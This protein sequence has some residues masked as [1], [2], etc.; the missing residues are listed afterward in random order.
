MALQ[1]LPGKQKRA[2]VTQ[3]KITQTAHG[4]QRGDLVYYSTVTAQ[5]ELAIAT[6]TQTIAHGIVGDFLADTFWLVTNGLFEW[7]GHG[8]N[9]STQYYLS[10]TNAGRA[11]NVEPASVVQKIFIPVDSDHLLLVGWVFQE[12][13]TSSKYCLAAPQG[14]GAPLTEGDL[15]VYTRKNGFAEFD[16][17]DSKEQVPVMRVTNVD[18]SVT[19][20]LIT[21][22]EKGYFDY[23]SSTG[24]DTL[25]LGKTVYA[26]P[27]THRI[28]DDSIGNDYSKPGDPTIP[29]I[30][31]GKIVQNLGGGSY[32]IV[33][34]P[35]FFGVD[36][37]VQEDTLERLDLAGVNFIED[38]ATFPN[39]EATPMAVEDVVSYAENNFYFYNR[40]TDRPLMIV[41]QLGTSNDPDLVVACHRGELI[42]YDL[43]Q[44]GITEGTVLYATVGSKVLSVNGHT[45]MAVVVKDNGTNVY[46]IWFDWSAFNRDITIMDTPIYSD[47]SI[48]RPDHLVWQKDHERDNFWSLYKNITG[49]EV[50]PEPFDITKW[51]RVHSSFKS[52]YGSEFTNSGL[53]S[54]GMISRLNSSTVH[55]AAGTG[56]IVSSSKTNP[57]AQKIEWVAQDLVLPDMSTDKYYYI[58]IDNAGIASYSTGL[59][60]ASYFKDKIQ[61]GWAVSD[62]DNPSEIGA[63]QQ[64]PILSQSYTDLLFDM[65]QFFVK[66]Q[67]IAGGLV[68][69]KTGTLNISVDQGDYYSHGSNFFTDPNNPNVASFSQMD[70]VVFRYID[71]EGTQFN[72]TNTIEV[73]QIEDTSTPGT[74]IPMTTDFAKIELLY[75]QPGSDEWIM[76]IGQTEYSSIQLGINQIKNYTQSVILPEILKQTA[77][78]VGAIVT[79]KDATDTDDMAMV[80]IHSFSGSTFDGASAGAQVL[81]DLLDVD[82]V[83]VLNKQIISYNSNNSMWEHSDVDEFFKWL[84]VP[85]GSYNRGDILAFTSAGWELAIANDMAKKAQAVV[86]EVVT[87]SITDDIKI[88]KSGMITEAGHGYTPGETYY[89]SETTPGTFTHNPPTGN[90]SF[91]QSIYYVTDPNNFII[92]IGIVESNHHNSDY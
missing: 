75:Y 24:S 28:N 26:N 7:S 85:T 90:F 10:D 88:T 16:V 11:T 55:I 48:Y 73:T 67:V 32:E 6:D 68:K 2:R 62:F 87:G 89:L 9:L 66:R 91:K 77:V 51:D 36:P 37:E 12:T 76:L 59:G 65:T 15:V 57:D 47:Q 17:Y 46:D 60:Y 63:V 44:L 42:D 81:G 50:G 19:P 39:G 14:T 53:I 86:S 80:Y 20:N 13:S 82:A 1:I 58:Y 29:G 31:V 74:L 54:G 56:V 92:D 78:P 52:P 40:S 64:R 61:L 41:K 43:G 45:P 71:S 23:T 3:E 25:P 69:G 8:F 49:A 38:C 84:Q 27:A 79:K 30:P 21:A 18:T 5:W 34:D 35:S 33:Y 70:P 22:C 72:Y 83:G 4:F